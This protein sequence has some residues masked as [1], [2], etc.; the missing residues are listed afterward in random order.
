M[1][2]KQIFICDCHSMEHQIVVNQVDDMVFFNFYI[3]IN[4][5]FYKRLV[6]CFSLIFLNKKIFEE[7]IFIILNENEEKKL[8]KY[9]EFLLYKIE[10][11]I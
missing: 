5:P 4:Q 2:D 10:D 7:D 3:D 8:K 9:L 11:F 6:N 1:E